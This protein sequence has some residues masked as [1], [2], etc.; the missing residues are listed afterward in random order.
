MDIKKLDDFLA[1]FKIIKDPRLEKEDIADLISQIVGKKIKADEVKIQ[2]KNL[3][4]RAHPAL[5]SIIFM[6]KD[7]VLAGVVEKYPDKGI[8]NLI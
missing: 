7:K 5:K 8:E 2:G 6:K 3:V 4:I 1:K